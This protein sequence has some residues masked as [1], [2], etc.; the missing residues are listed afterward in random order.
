LDF[1]RLKFTTGSNL[2]DRLDEIRI[3]QTVADCASFAEAARR[4]GL[5]SVTASRAVAALEKRLGVSLLQRTTRSVR[6]TSAGEQYLVRSR[7]ALADLED[8]A[9]AIQD[10]AHLRGPLVLTAPVQFGRQ[11]ISPMLSTLLQKH[12]QLTAR[13]IL[14][15]RV[16]RL[17]E[18]GIDAA[19]RIGHLA[20]S[21]LKSTRIGTVRPMWVASAAY[22]AKH[23]TPG[24]V[25]DLRGHSLV[26]FDSAT[27]SR[28]WRNHGRATG[29]TP[30][31]VTDSVDAAADAVL[32]GMGIARL[33]SYHVQADVAAGRL[34]HVL[35]ADD[36]GPIPVNLVYSSCHAASA[37]IKAFLNVAREG[38]AKALRLAA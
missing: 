4:L 26:Q 11:Y 13:L 3:F 38:F 8:A 37:P 30:R 35:P 21:T 27:L 24:A 2:M 28:E 20:D 12:A 6:M 19:L 18:D 7:R 32:D 36:G 17:V 1:E 33:L 5:P 31:F 10:D 16:L 34:T 15:D 23:G 9:S 25:A 29:V 14:T 22:L